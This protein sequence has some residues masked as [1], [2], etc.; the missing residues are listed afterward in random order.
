MPQSAAPPQNPNASNAGM[1]TQNVVSIFQAYI[2]TVLAASR[3]I[4]PLP[5]SQANQSNEKK[6][7]TSYLLASQPPPNRNFSLAYQQLD[8]FT[9]PIVQVP[10]PSSPAAG[11]RMP[12]SAAP[13]QDPDVSNSGM[14]PLARHLY[15]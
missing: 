10:Y 8:E 3:T 5:S 2:L 4:L 1:I 9:E 13:A 11:T 6:P 15:F 14:V 12:P 7:S